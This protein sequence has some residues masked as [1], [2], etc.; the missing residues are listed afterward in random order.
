MTNIMCARSNSSSYLCR[1]LTP[2][3]PHPPHRPPTLLTFKG[4]VGGGAGGRT[5]CLYY[6]VATIYCTDEETCTAREGLLL[7]W[8]AGSEDG[9]PDR[10]DLPR[11]RCLPILLQP[12]GS[13]EEQQMTTP[14]GGGA[15][16]EG[17]RGGYKLHHPSLSLMTSC[18]PVC[19]EFA[20]AG[21]DQR[22]APRRFCQV[23]DCR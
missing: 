11:C 17:G 8:R 1:L 7:L 14:V 10:G 20:A 3:P 4:V 13:A 16:E 12:P 21:G 15:R 9:L 18:R 23:L 5:C 22:S 6:I 2:H 19:C